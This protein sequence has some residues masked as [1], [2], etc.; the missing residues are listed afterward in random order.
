MEKCPPQ[1]RYHRS[2]YRKRNENLAKNPISHCIYRPVC[3]MYGTIYACRHWLAPQWNFAVSL[4]CTASNT[5]WLIFK[6]SA[7]ATVG[8]RRIDHF[9]WTS[10]ILQYVTSRFFIT[11]KSDWTSWLAWLYGRVRVWWAPFLPLSWW[12]WCGI[13]FKQ[14]QPLQR[15]RPTIIPFGM[16][17]SRPSPFVTSTKSI[18]LLPRISLTNCNSSSVCEEKNTSTLIFLPWIFF[19]CANVANSSVTEWKKAWR[20]RR[21]TNFWRI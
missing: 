11:G 4:R 13:G 18:G 2:P 9:H 17:H 12:V 15:S 19:Y 21:S 14:R 20:K 8:M 1:Y 16:S 3:R 6:S 7:L 10:E 5:L